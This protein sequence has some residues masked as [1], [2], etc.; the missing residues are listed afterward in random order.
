[1]P[2]PSLCTIQ[3]P[4]LR[5]GERLGP[6]QWASVLQSVLDPKALGCHTPVASFGGFSRL[7][8]PPTF[9]ILTPGVNL[10]GGAAWMDSGSS[11]W[12]P[13]G[14]SE[15]MAEPGVQ[16]LELGWLGDLGSKTCC[17]WA[18]VVPSE[19]GEKKR[20]KIVK[21]LC[22]PA[23]KSLTHLLK[24]TATPTDRLEDQEGASQTLRGKRPWRG[25]TVAGSRAR[26]GSVLKRRTAPPTLGRGPAW[27]GY[28]GD[29][30]SSLGPPLANEVPF[31]KAIITP[32]VK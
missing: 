25:A 23:D 27:E 28:V 18:S 29:K 12:K 3:R 10:A 22:S 6:H 17:F 4:A 32:S 16:V 19:K 13:S 9:C 11:D 30:M 20:R 26:L 2:N 5:Y 8:W 21:I 24:S 7:P 31:A 14:V 1:M 15:A